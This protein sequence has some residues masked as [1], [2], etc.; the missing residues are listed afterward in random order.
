MIRGGQRLT[1]PNPHGSA[2]SGQLIARMLRQGGISEQ[3]WERLA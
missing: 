1:I 3:E 2:I